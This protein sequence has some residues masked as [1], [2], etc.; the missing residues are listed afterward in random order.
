MDK[1]ATNA[2]DLQLEKIALGEATPEGPLSKEDE[3]RLAALRQ[4]NAQILARY[5]AGPQ[6][7]QIAARVAAA[8]KLTQKR[9]QSRWLLAPRV[10]GAAGP[11]GPEGPD[12]IL[13]K[14]GAPRGAAKLLLYRSRDGHT[15][16]LS[17]GAAASPGDLL[18]LALVPGK[19]RYGVLVSIDGRG[20]VTVH[21][22]TAPAESP[23]L[24]SGSA[25]PPPSEAGKIVTGEIRLP[26]AFRLDDAPGFE[27][28]FLITAEGA[29]REALSIDQV[30]AQARSL[31]ADRARAEREPIPGLPSGLTQTSLI[32]RKPETGGGR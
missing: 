9:A 30:V 22:P 18:Q 7:Q 6:A 19:A 25:A 28:F 2:T 1:P 11:E 15:E 14:G 5:P 31:A 29:G 8:Q 20:G 10:L 12:V 16:P 17:D 23:S 4:D 26:Q 24:F 32:L 27:R 3:A 21:H 13:T